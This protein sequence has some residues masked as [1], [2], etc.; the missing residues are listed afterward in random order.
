MRI[1]R[2]S[3]SGDPDVADHGS[4]LVLRSLEDSSGHNGG[5]LQFGPDGKLYFASGDGS[6][7]P[8]NDADNNAQNG[9]SMHGKVLRIDVDNP[10]ASVAADNPYVGDDGTLDGDRIADRA[11]A[12][13]VTVMGAISEFVW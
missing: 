2:Y 9:L 8:N 10:P 13:G 3:V 6:T 5:Q 11:A 7:N 1:A 12:A 4:Q